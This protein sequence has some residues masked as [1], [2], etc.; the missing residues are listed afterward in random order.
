MFDFGNRSRSECIALAQ[1]VWLEW[2]GAPRDFSQTIRLDTGK[3]RVM[4]EGSENLFIAKRRR[5]AD[6][7]VQYLTC[8]QVRTAA[9]VHVPDDCEKVNKELHF[10]SNKQYK[11]QI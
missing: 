4:K 5:C 11:N 9:S 6:E 2:Y 7:T 10:Q 3:K 8:E 1:K